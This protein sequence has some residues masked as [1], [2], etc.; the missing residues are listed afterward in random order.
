MRDACGDE[1]AIS[2]LADFVEI[3]IPLQV[4]LA[5]PLALAL[6]P[7][8]TPTPTPTLTLTPTLAPTL[9]LT[10]TLPL[11]PLQRAAYTEAQWDRIENPA[12]PSAAGSDGDEGCEAPADGAAAQG[13]T[14]EN[15]TRPGEE[16]EEGSGPPG[17]ATPC[18]P[19]GCLSDSDCGGHGECVRGVCECNGGYL[20][21]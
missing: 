12:P 10:L 5:L 8:P 9:T 2:G 7:T 20:G 13:N 21:A 3:A 17:A 1:I 6:T 19:G 14:T 18:F 16:S 4:S 11:T 15:I